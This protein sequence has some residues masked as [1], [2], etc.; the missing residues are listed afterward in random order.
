MSTALTKIITLILL[1]TQVSFRT[2]L[3]LTDPEPNPFADFL[4]DERVLEATAQYVD[5]LNLVAEDS[6]GEKFLGEFAEI[7]KYRSG[8]GPADPQEFFIGDKLRILVN[9]E[10]QIL[11]VQNYELGFNDELIG[12]VLAV[13]EDYFLF[14]DLEQQTLQINFGTQTEL[15]DE[16]GQRIFNYVLQKGDVLRVHGILNQNSQIVFTET[17]GAYL[18]LLSA[19]A[20]TA[21]FPEAAERVAAIQASTTIT[22]PQIFV[23]PQEPSFTDVPPEHLYFTAIEFMHANK[24]V[25]GYPSGLFLA[26]DPINRAEFT[27]ILSETKFASELG[28]LETDLTESCFPDFTL[29]EWFAK[30]VCLMKNKGIIQGYPDGN[31]SAANSINRAEAAKIAVKIYQPDLPEPQTQEEWFQPA[32]TFLLQQNIWSEDYQNEPAAAITRGEFANL[33]FQLELWQTTI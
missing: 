22:N 30:Y 6:T 1:L 32:F 29:T 33:I 21:I 5:E 3:G 15:R 16:T 27:K 20:I 23:P 2:A 13:A 19:A 18:V 10:N 28:T 9:A 24:I 25:A 14:E 8:A 17:F 4:A 31:F 26:E 11:A 12:F 7:P